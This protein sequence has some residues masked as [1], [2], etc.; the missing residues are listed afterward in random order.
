[1]LDICFKH[2]KLSF[3]FL[4]NECIPYKVYESQIYENIKENIDMFS[5]SG[6]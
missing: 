5:E 3:I 1:M 4:C 6:C 2:Y